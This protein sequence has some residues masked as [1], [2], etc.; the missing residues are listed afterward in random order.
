MTSA[1]ILAGGS[2]KRMGDEV[3]KL[4]LHIA[5]LP[6]LARVLLT[7]E[8]STDVD[9]II[10]VARKDRQDTYRNLA[11]E[12]RI[13]KLTSA[14]PGGI[15]RQDSV[16]CGIQAVSPNSKIVLIHDSARALVT[17]DI[18]S[19]CVG[20]ARQTGAVIPVTRIKDTIKRAISRANTHSNGSSLLVETTVDRSLLWAA[21]TPQT[22]WTDLIR[23]AYELVTRDHLVITD[24]A[25]AVEHLGHPVSMV[26]CDSSN[27]KI[28]TPED[29]L[30]AEVILS[31]R[32]SLSPL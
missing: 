5:G 20:V 12:H 24:D 32:N 2:S 18:I 3:D 28:T 26:E 7:F 27:L 22:F 8:H 16:W 14:I 30:L 9:E 13:S 4:M 6:L 15:E 10:L 25:S 17:S 29:L 11:S 1:I 21:Q 23:R 19:R 31:K